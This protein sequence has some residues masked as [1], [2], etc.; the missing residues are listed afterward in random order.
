MRDRSTR[1]SVDRQQLQEIIANLI[2]GVLILDPDGAIAWANRAALD[3]HGCRG[4]AD[5]GGSPVGYRRRFALRYLNHHKLTARQYPLDR[6]EAGHR[7]DGMTV[8]V[9]HRAG[10]DFRRVLELRGFPVGSGSKAID[11]LVLIMKDVTERQSADERFERAFAA[12]PAPAVILRLPDSHYVKANPGFLEM[13][14]FTQDQVGDRAFR[15]LD[16]LHGAEHREAA[17]AAMRE[18]RTIPQQE[19]VLRVA[20]GADKFVIV[21]G[22]PIDMDDARCMLFTFIDLDARKRAEM[23]LRRSED[24][25]AKAFRLA[26]VPM[27]LCARPEWRVVAANDAFAAIT[28]YASAETRERTIREIGFWEGSIVLDDLRASLDAGR[29]VRDL[30]VS[31]RTHAGAKIDCLVSAEPVTVQDQ[32]CVLLVVQDI[33]ERKR[34]ETDVSRAIEAVM[35]DTSWFSHT[36]LEKLAQIRNPAAGESELATLTP[37]ETEILGLICRGNGNAEIAATLRLSANTV[38]NHIANLYGKIGVRR[39]SAAIVWGRER[40]IATY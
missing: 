11:L 2:E 12:N 39:R 33:T 10:G 18:H 38:R 30:E 9:A 19:A 6:L 5:L 7:F 1:R 4:A 29:D 27:L 40:G 34:L 16:V 23:S 17:L 15:E 24:Q 32:A 20:G 25:F 35:K 22:Q 28:G 14:G 3:A 36:V 31:L 26:P 8:E 37:R 13:T 21:A